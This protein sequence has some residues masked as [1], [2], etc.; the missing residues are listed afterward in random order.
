MF[1]IVLPESKTFF[2]LTFFGRRTKKKFKLI[3]K[4]HFN[5]V[6]NLKQIFPQF[7]N[8]K[9]KIKKIFGVS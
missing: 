6:N 7:V 5:N 2:V 3:L 8:F 9:T 1:N 4:K